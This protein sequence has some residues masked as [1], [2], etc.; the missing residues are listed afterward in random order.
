MRKSKRNSDVWKRMQQRQ[1]EIA[2][3]RKAG[4]A[5]AVKTKQAKEAGNGA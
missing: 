4:A 2:A 1:A 3:N 5:K